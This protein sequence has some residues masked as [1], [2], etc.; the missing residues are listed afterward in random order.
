MKPVCE[1]ARDRK[2]VRFLRNTVLVVMLHRGAMSHFSH[3]SINL[4]SSA[5]FGSFP[6]APHFSVAVGMR[7]AYVSMAA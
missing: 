1:F 5:Y 2:Q 3:L 4:I 6:A 7:S